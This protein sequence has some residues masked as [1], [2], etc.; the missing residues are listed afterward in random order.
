MLTLGT[1]FAIL[2]PRLAR[3]FSGSKPDAL[4][5]GLQRR[6]S[7][8]DLNTGLLAENQA[9]LSSR[10]QEQILPTGLAPVL[11]GRKPDVL[12]ARR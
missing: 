4:S 3:G 12:A 11:P 9:S 7:R 1:N 6:C 8:R 2:S 10:L 5:L